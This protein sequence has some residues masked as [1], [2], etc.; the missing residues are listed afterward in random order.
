MKTGCSE[1]ASLKICFVAFEFREISVLRKKLKS[2][3]IH[4][5]TR[6]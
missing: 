5:S 2:F 3:L 4:Q 6:Q 1:T